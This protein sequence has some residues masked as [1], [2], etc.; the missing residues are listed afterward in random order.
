[1]SQRPGQGGKIGRATGTNCLILK[2]EEK[3][4]VI[5]MPSSEVKRINNENTCILGK[6]ASEERKRLGKAG[7]SRR[8]GIRP[9]VK[10]VVM[11]AVDHPNGGKTA[12]GIPKTL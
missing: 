6:V 5:R 12:G 3:I 10:G 1:M 4:T 11:N 8:R 9:T 7:A 2:Q